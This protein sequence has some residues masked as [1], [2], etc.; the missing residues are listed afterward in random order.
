MGVQ[1]IPAASMA[2]AMRHLLVEE[3]LLAL[4]EQAESRGEDAGALRLMAQSERRKAADA[5]P[6]FFPRPRKRKVK[7]AGA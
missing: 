3:R 1:V 4:A 2:V 5:L 6:P 7:P